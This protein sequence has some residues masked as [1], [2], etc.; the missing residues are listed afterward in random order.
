MRVFLLIFFIL[1]SASS[2]HAEEP[3]T[4][5]RFATLK[6]DMVNLRTGP[7]FRYP[8]DWVLTRRNMPVEVTDVFEQWRKV[9]TM[10]K[11]EGWVH[12]TALSGKRY[13][14]ALQESIL[15]KKANTHSPVVAYLDE[16]V[17]MRMVSCPKAKDFCEVDIEGIQG[18]I[19]RKN[20][21]GIYAGEFTK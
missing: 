3:R 2:L 4:L 6:S 10:D 7:G 5:P 20:L 18:F 19:A 15:Y 16:G 17:Q 13:F 12:Q 21:Y 9:R 14:V 1:F 11:D 8:I